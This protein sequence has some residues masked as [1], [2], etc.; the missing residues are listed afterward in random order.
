M[1]AA[2]LNDMR[3][4]KGI[5]AE[6]YSDCTRFVIQ[7]DGTVKRKCFIMLSVDEND[8]E[9]TIY[10]EV[11]KNVLRRMIEGLTADLLLMEEDES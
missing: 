5:R 6:A 4:Y 7:K 11:G 8:P 1:T 3:L 2:E 10:L 9:M